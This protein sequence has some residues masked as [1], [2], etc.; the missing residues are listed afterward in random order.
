MYSL[1]IDT[2]H[3]ENFIGVLNLQKNLIAHKRFLE[4][5]Y[6]VLIGHLSDLFKDLDIQLSDITHYYTP[7][8]PGSTLGIR[9]AQMTINGLLG[10]H[11]GKNDPSEMTKQVYRYNGLYMSALHLKAQ[12]T[13][14]GSILITENGR[15][16]WSL[17][18]IDKVGNTE[19]FRMDNPSIAEIENNIYY[20]PQVK[21]WQDPPKAAIHL[22]YDPENFL[23]LF[24]LPEASNIDQ[25]ILQ[26]YSMEYKKWNS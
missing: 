1:I 20:I 3:E 12:S 21:R 15:D 16:A 13:P 19:I 9:T 22:K 14:T 26:P 4:P 18:S 24:D 5:P 10:A 2:S 6:E 25:T 23:K 8:S 7:C 11:S 17:I